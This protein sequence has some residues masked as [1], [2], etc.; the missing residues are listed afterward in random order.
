LKAIPLPTA[1]YEYVLAFGVKETPL[2]AELRHHTTQLD[3][4][5][6]QILPEQG[7]FLALLVRL[8]NARRTIEVGVFRG[9]SALWMAQALP[10]D[11]V[12]IGCDTSPDWTQT[13]REYWSRSDVGHKIDLRLAPAL[14]TL[15][16]LLEQGE[17][18]CFDFVFIDADKANNRHYYECALQ[19]L[20]V[21]G[22]VVIDNTLRYGSVADPTHTETSVMLLRAFNEFVYHDERVYMMLVPIGDGMTVAIKQV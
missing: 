16:T 8:V 21:G 9:Y 5:Q 22:V 11:G 3:Q 2:L 1:L 13:A 12:L 20:R 6:N 10:P 14:D 4:P 7:Q 15:N 19:L 17:A 18:G